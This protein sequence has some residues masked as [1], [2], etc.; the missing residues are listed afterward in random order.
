EDVVVAE[1]ARREPGTAVVEVLAIAVER[2]GLGEQQ[3]AGIIV[4]D[5]DL[6]QTP[7][8]ASTSGT[9]P[10]ASGVPQLHSVDE[11]GGGGGKP[12][13]LQAGGGSKASGRNGGTVILVPVQREV[14]EGEG[15]AAAAV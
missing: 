3:P 12:A 1:F 11:H 4:P 6:V 7:D 15:G 5:D 9:N 13:G 2:R 8:V 14:L 10:P